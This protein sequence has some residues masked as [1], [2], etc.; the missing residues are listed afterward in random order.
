MR[1]APSTANPMYWSARSSSCPPYRRCRSWQKLDD[2]AQRFLQVVARDVGELLEVAVGPLQVAGLLVEAA[3]GLLEQV[4]L[5]G[6]VHPHRVDVRAELDDLLR[7]AAPD[8]PVHVAGHHG[9]H[10]VRKGRDAVEDPAAQPPGRGGEERGDGDGDRDADPAQGVRCAVEPFRAASRSASRT[11][12][13]RSS[14]AR[15]RVERVLPMA[16]SGAT[17]PSAVATTGSA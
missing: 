12:V 9:A 5:V 6:D 4:D 14:G 11:A 2:L 8:L 16:G 15:D 7:A 3:V 13:S 10:L 17:E 1:C